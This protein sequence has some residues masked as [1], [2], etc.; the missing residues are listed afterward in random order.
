[1]T[2]K[3]KKKFQFPVEANT[4]GEI[5]ATTG[6]HTNNPFN[7]EDNFAGDSVDDHKEFEA[8]NE[9]LAKKQL[10]QLNNNL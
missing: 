8:A 2:E 3:P 6:L 4:N 9:H 7:Q 10:S 1:M 5:S